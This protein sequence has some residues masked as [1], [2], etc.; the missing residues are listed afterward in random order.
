MD[1]QAEFLDEAEETL[2][3]LEGLFLRAEDSIVD[4]T[5]LD[6]CFRAA[7][8]LKGSALSVGFSGLGALAHQMEDF[9]DRVRDE[10]N[11]TPMIRI[12][13]L[14][15][16]H[17]LL[18]SYVNGLRGNRD[19]S[20]DI[21][22]LEA[23]V[24]THMQ[25]VERISDESV[26]HKDS[27]LYYRAYIQ[28]MRETF[29]QEHMEL[30]ASFSTLAIPFHQAS[31]FAELAHSAFST[32]PIFKSIARVCLVRRIGFAN[33]LEVI[34]SSNDG[35]VSLMA[36]GYR[37][38]VDAK[39]SLFNISNNSIRIYA[40]AQK[41]IERYQAEGRPA[42]RSISRIA[43]MKLKSG[44]CFGIFS[45]SSM[46]GLLFL[47]ARDEFLTNI[48]KEYLPILSYLS[49][50]GHKQFL[51]TL[52]NILYKEV[53]NAERDRLVGSTFESKLLIQDILWV[54]KRIDPTVHSPLKIKFDG[55]QH[56]P[57]LLVHGHAS[58][59]IAQMA[60]YLRATELR[61]VVSVFDSTIQFRCIFIAEAS[62]A[63]SPNL[64]TMIHEAVN[65][66][67]RAN[68]VSSDTVHLE[69]GMDSDG[70]NAGT[71]YS[72]EDDDGH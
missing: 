66:G 13:E 32:N 1:F 67:Y 17:D 44:A 51:G 12:N 49:M 6:E 18:I 56:Y 70:I 11:P 25:K 24:L 59:L 33:Q 10:R 50:L 29:Q 2:V 26:F 61:I 60:V 39:G 21:G 54:M 69:T 40:S 36:N 30:F 3:R 55:L 65:L 7:H 64:R 42:Q 52:P 28:G 31:S 34:S 43:A 22:D 53:W 58:Y 27:N 5:L 19:F 8:N 9:L 71:H 57:T 16:Y 37:C 20:M 41:I 4:R 45:G 68:L 46:T 72:I 62:F 14:L 63:D 23:P 38:F 48:P 15:R 47:N 35:S